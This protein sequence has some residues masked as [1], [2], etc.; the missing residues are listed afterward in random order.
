MV[1]VLNIYGSRA[2]YPLFCAHQITKSDKQEMEISVPWPILT[3]K[4]VEHSMGPG[5]DE[6]YLFSITT[7]SG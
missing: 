4:I 6:N 7:E 2:I 1:A 5:I 3:Q